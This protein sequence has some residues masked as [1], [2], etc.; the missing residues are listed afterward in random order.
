[1]GGAGYPGVEPQAYISGGRALACGGIYGA[2]GGV[3]DPAGGTG[4]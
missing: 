3:R 4:G 2:V 1:M